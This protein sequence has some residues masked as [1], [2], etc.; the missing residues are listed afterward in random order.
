MEFYGQEEARLPSEDY[1]ER[2]R[3]GGRER[4]GGRWRGRWRWS[5]R[6]REEG[7]GG[8]EE[9]KRE[10]VMEREKGDGGRR[11]K[12]VVGGREGVFHARFTLC[13]KYINKCKE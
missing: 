5:G 12:D 13:F 6:G 2:G 3:A 4:K 7:E 1:D 8:E 10:R 11:G 9:E